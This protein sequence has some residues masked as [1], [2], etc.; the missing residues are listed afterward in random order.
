MALWAPTGP[1][2]AYEL[3]GAGCG[4]V[5]RIGPVRAQ[6]GGGR[7]RRTFPTPSR[8]PK[9]ENES[10]KTAPRATPLL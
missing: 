2:K 7:E 1:S 10:P 6:P 4:P 8:A 3:N 5:G 9:T